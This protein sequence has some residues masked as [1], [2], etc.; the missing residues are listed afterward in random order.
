[1]RGDARLLGD[2]AI[3]ELRRAGFTFVR[4]PVQPDLLDAPDALADAVARLQRHGLAVVVSLFRWTGTWKPPRTTARVLAAWRSLAPRCARSIRPR[5][6]QRCSTSRFSRTTR[7]LGA[8]AASRPL[9]EIRASLPA[10]TIV[11]TGKDWGSI[12][13]LLA[14]SPEP[15]P[16]RDLQLPPVRAGGVD[17]ACRLPA[18]AGCR[19]IGATAVS[20]QPMRRP[21]RPP[22]PPARF[23]DR[24]SD[25]VLLCQRWD[26][27]KLAARIAAAG[28]WARR[29][30]VALLAGEF[31]A[32][33]A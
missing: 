11:L 9:T 30:H 32:A 19:R 16:Q 23:A 12:D 1:M 3:E 33:S 5:R 25:A 21:A 4:L 27:A 10:N 7:R 26:A 18:R 14:L 2:P 24:R 15:D 20:R 17:R 6:F 8:A 22:P 31:G 13:G 29:N 28:A